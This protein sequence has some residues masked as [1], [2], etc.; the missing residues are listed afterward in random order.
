MSTLKKVISLVLC[1][2]L[3]AGSFAF[4][5]DLIMPKA[6]AEEPTE[7]VLGSKPLKTYADLADKY[8]KFI[9]IGVDVYELTTDDKGETV[10]TLTDG[11]V[12]A[13]QWLEYR[14]TIL[15]DL[16]IGN[17]NTFYLYD[18]RF[19]DITRTSTVAGDSALSENGYETGITS[20]Y[21]DTEAH[22]FNASHPMVVE[23]VPT[24]GYTSSPCSSQS[25]FQNGYT[26]IDESVYTN[27]DQ[28][29]QVVTY[30]ATATTTALDMTTDAWYLKWYAKVLDEPTVTEATSYSPYSLYKISPMNGTSTTMGDSRVPGNI[31]S[32][33]VNDGGAAPARTTCKNMN[34]AAQFKS[35][36]FLCEDSYTNFVI[37]V[38]EE[39]PAEEASEEP[40]EEEEEYTVTEY[41][42]PVREEKRKPDNMVKPEMDEEGMTA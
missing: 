40:V 15:S 23:K 42:P 28:A 7:V 10:A 38:P 36:T 31:A 9:Y 26:L 8:D 18:N 30:S 5:G 17:I 11:K 21:S 19:F 33:T 41:V 37:E 27:L 16:W 4:A 2:S 25:Y 1:L 22:T 14:E 13:G 20:V 35:I 12:K 32:S 34:V 24:V 6:A 39:E 29:G 3:L